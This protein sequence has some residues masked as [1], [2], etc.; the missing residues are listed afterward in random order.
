MTPED[1]SNLS[2]AEIWS[3]AVP[4]PGHPGAHGFLLNPQHFDSKEHLAQTT[5]LLMRR[6]LKT[7]DKPD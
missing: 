7:P 3:M 1:I 4:R 5:Y 2:D 6:L